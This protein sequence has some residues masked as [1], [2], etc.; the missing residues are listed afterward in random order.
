MAVDIHS[1]VQHSN[2]IERACCFSVEQ[3]LR[4]RGV[5]LIPIAYWTDTTEFVGAGQGLHR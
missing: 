5:L 4:A 1:L 3:D 2:D